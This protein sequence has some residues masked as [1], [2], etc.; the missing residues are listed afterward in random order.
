MFTKNEGTLDRV[1]RSIVGITALVLGSFVLTGAIK[2]VAIVIGLVA[3][4]TGLLGF[5]GLYAL[6]GI[7]TCSVKK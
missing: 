1:I 2:V 5:C 4:A 3:L 6:L 7:N